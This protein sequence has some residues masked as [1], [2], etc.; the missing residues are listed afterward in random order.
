MIE[1]KKLVFKEI[2]ERVKNESGFVL[3][4]YK[5][6]TAGLISDLR[7]AIHHSGGTFFV[8]KKR[9]LLKSLQEEKM[10]Y[11]LAD[12]EGHVGL[13]TSG[14]DFVLTTKALFDF[15]KA[16]DSTVKVLGAVFEGKQC[17]PDEVKQISLLPDEK[18]MKGQ[19]IGVLQAPMTQMLGVVH[20]L[21]TS[22]M[23]CLENK[24]KKES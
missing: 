22:P 19:L 10:Q 14:K 11:E 2:S 18:T 12:L 13:V 5:N 24:V 3:A 15:T 7:G 8:L 9:L 17:S 21:L 20:S 16:N 23:H 1:E 4:S 6:L